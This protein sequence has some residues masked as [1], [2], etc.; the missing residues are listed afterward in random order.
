[1]IVKCLLF[2]SIWF[3]W[4]GIP[5]CVC[6]VPSVHLILPVCRRVCWLRLQSRQETLPQAV[7]T[8]GYVREVDVQMLYFGVTL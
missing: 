3:I 7:H 4:T 8:G 1:M 6:D 2:K 5:E